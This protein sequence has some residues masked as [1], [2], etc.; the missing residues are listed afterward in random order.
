MKHYVALLALCTAMAT[1]AASQP[2]PDDNRLV[3]LA[4][5]VTAV[6]V[7]VSLPADLPPAGTY[8]PEGVL[9]WPIA[10][11][12]ANARILP[13][14]LP[15]AAV[16]LLG[17]VMRGPFYLQRLY[18]D[19]FEFWWM[20]G[21]DEQA[22]TAT[23]CRTVLRPDRLPAGAL[24]TD[25]G[26]LQLVQPRICQLRPMPGVPMAMLA[27]A[28]PLPEAKTLPVREMASTQL[29]AR[30]GSVWRATILAA[31]RDPLPRFAL[32][33]RPWGKQDWRMVMPMPWAAADQA[34]GV[35]GSYLEVGLPYDARTGII[36]RFSEP[37]VR[38]AWEDQSYRLIVCRLEATVAN[39]ALP[40]D[41]ALLGWCGRA[42]L[43]AGRQVSESPGPPV[44]APP[45]PP[46]SAASPR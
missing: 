10:L 35:K 17:E 15:P 16:G 31:Q 5:F 23:L 44:V 38:K 24:L 9:N 27:Q 19:R 25:F 43:A 29:R 13:R 6:P 45:S 21:F 42:G 36:L 11:V 26:F 18:P 7:A 32:H 34:T 12:E 46:R 3:P 40:A 1:S 41:P 4:D 30:D 14:L 22:R 8:Y 39:A 37:D 2:G 20:T 33:S 28:R